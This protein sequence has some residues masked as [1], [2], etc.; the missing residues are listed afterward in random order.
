MGV[1]SVARRDR[2][3]G[4]G[5][6]II[7]G[8]FV[9]LGIAQS[10]GRRG[11]PV[12][13]IDDERS[14]TRFSRYSA[15]SIHVPDLRD[16]QHLLDELEQARVRHGLDGW[17]LYPTREEHVAALS[18]ARAALSQ[19]F[20]VPTPE[21]SVT[22]WA[23][24]KRNTYRMAGELGIPTPKTWYPAD[25]ADLAAVD[26]EPPYVIKPAIKERF[27]YATK[28]KAWQ[29]DDRE[30][31]AALFA[32]ASQLTGPGGTMVQEM[33]PG[34]GR[35]QYAYCALFKEGRSLASMQARRRRQHPPVFGKATT[36]AETVDVPVLEELSQRFLTEIDYYGLVELE[37]KLDDRTGE[38]KLLDVNARNWGYH[39]LG[40]AAGVDFSHLLFADQVGE[41]FPAVRAR[42]GVS[43]IRL[44]TDIP[45]AAVEL[46]GGRLAVRD[47]LRTLRGV[48]AEAVFSLRDPLPFVAEVA[49]VPYLYRKRGF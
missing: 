46:A 5:G 43:W 28:K 49:M 3:G 35:Q 44:L 36:Y 47:Y 19:R 2:L 21:W 42:P 37:Y 4:P 15:R 16:P 25:A 17:V 32:R 11:I 41:T 23:W 8:D 31:L 1:F 26:G 48:D 12:I 33:I 30:E 24:D 14:V 45:T 10:L 9:G 29:A 13:V 40:R 39:G 18:M 38:Y 34:D 6:V 20:R 27:L 22:K 7:G